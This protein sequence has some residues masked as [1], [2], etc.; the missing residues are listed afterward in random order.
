M[1]HPSMTKLHSHIRP[2]YT[3]IDVETKAHCFIVSACTWKLVKVTAQRRAW[4]LLGSS[5]ALWR[6]RLLT[7][8]QW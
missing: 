8:L 4:S 1:P 2:A 3:R 6:C 7:W 5:R